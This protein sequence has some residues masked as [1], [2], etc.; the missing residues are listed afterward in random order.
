[1]A[2]NLSGPQKTKG[3]IGRLLFRRQ[4]CRS[5]RTTGLYIRPIVIPALRKRPCYRP[6]M[7]P[8][9]FCGRHLPSG[10]FYQPLNF[11]PENK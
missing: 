11:I 5:W 6:G 7:R 8:T 4:L 3:Y 1:M 2:G 10:H 9:S